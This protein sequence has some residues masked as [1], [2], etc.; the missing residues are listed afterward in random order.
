MAAVAPDDAERLASAL[1]VEFR[2]LG[3]VVAQSP[4][5]LLRIVGMSQSGVADLIV[6]A[7]DLFTEAMRSDLQ[8]VRIDPFDPKLRQYLVGSMG[9]LPD[10]VLRILFL[11][12]QRRLIADEQLQQ[13]SLANLALYPRTLFRRALEH[14]AAAIILVHNHPSGDPKPSSD[15]IRVTQILEQVGRALD[16]QILDHLIVTRSQVHHV[17]SEAVLGRAPAASQSFTLRSDASSSDDAATRALANAR[18]TMRRRILR[19][20][21]IGS[22]ELF[23]E[24][25]WDM[26][27]DL[28][29]HESER[30]PLSLSSLCIQAS[31]PWSSALRLIQKLCDAGIM[32]RE[33][34]PA[35]GRRS[36]MRLEQPIIHRLNA[37]FAEGGE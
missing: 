32:R 35:D 26:L 4:E 3:N 33:P 17:T 12:G 36:F 13:G 29:I 24:P 22:S 28:F 6:R 19:Q 37:Y 5:A 14:N 7:R 9:A 11:D 31:I 16:V 18:S 10:E 20:Q 34:D 15:D 2:S 25:A 23:G 21:L 1:L 8:G 30:R 27:I